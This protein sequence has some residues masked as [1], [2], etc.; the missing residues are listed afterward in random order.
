MPHHARSTPPIEW[1]NDEVRPSHP[2]RDTAARVLGLGLLFFA[3]VT[4]AAAQDLLWTRQFGTSASEDGAAVAVD[5]AGNEYIT[6]YTYG[7]L[8][9]PNAGYSDAFL[10]K[11]DAAGVLLWTRQFGTSAGD[12]GYGVAADGAGNAYIAG[13]TTGSFGGPNAGYSDAFLAKF[14]ASGTLLWTRQV[15]TSATDAGIGVAVDDA[16]NA[17]MTGYT[18]GSLGGPNAGEFDAFLAKFD[19]SGTLLW[20]HQVGTPAQDLGFSLAVDGAGTAFITGYTWGSLGGPIAGETDAFLAKYDP[21]GVLLWT[22]QFG[23][24]AG[25][26]G[27]AAAVDGAGNAYITG[28]TYGNLAG[29]NAGFEDVFLA[30]FDASGVLLW[31]RQFGTSA[32]DAGFGVAAD[33]AGIAYITGSTSGSLGGPNAGYSDA[34]LAKFDALGTLLGTSQAGSS[35]DD[36]A[37]GVAV[38]DAD[39]AYITGYTTGS[40]GGPNAGEYDCFLA[41]FGPP[42]CDAD[43]DGNGALD[44]FDFLT[45]VNL[46]N[47][48]DPRADCDKNG[49]HDLFDFL[50][51]VNSFNAGC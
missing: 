43:L 2:R 8:A 41:K 40:L 19:A 16:G 30:K 14:D 42:P 31:M 5:G 6:G 35:M 4:P 34:F 7:E 47:A 15:G 48:A 50:C 24:S 37:W 20:T 51:F 3:P 39:N 29:P 36:T 10:A 46:F 28:L 38:D 13:G 11:F 17:Y 45:F 49:T 22:R 27:Q 23:T 12:A 9:G 21:S 1:H 44:L 33:D 25:D 26:V 18:E 32:G